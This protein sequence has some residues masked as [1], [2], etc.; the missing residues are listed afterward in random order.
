M[1]NNTSLIPVEDL[2]PSRIGGTEKIIQR[3][4]PIVY[5][6]KQSDVA[7]PLDASQLY[8]YNENGYLVLSDYMSEM[9]SPLQD[10]VNR[11]KKTMANND[12]LITEPDSRDIR[13]IFMPNAYSKLVDRFSRHPKVLNIARQLLD[14]DVYITQARVNVKPAFNGRSFA[15]HSDFETWHVED[16]M[17][18]MRAVTAW[19]MLTEN[20][21][22]NGPLYVIPGSH[23]N[24]ISCAG[25]TNKMNYTQ[26]LKRQQAG[27][28]RPETMQR[29]LQ[30]L[31]IQSIHGS[32]GSMVFHDCN[33]LHASPDNIS[34]MPRTV[35]MLVFN[36]C[37]NKLEKPFSYKS[38][39]PIYLR[40]PDA[41]ALDISHACTQAG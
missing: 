7:P 31:E 17:P 36:S 12:E 30:N 10:E 16:G 26:S 22:F 32:P 29:I 2:Y 24:Y 33:L 39:R 25:D 19:I 28:A 40:N 27:I 20:N 1:E 9:V 11:L 38:P 21:E 34:G 6:D 4:D 14:S 41:T 15:W 35:L 3:K 8:S 13:S 23:K 18:R 37:D 5:G